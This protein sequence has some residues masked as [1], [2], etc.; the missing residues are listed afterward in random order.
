MFFLIVSIP[1]TYLENNNEN[2]EKFSSYDQIMNS[3][4]DIFYTKEK[5]K[6]RDMDKLKKIPIL[7]NPLKASI[8]KKDI[9]QFEIYLY[10][11]A[12]QYNVFY[13]IFN[14]YW[15]HIFSNYSSN[16]NIF[17]YLI[18]DD[19]KKSSLDLS[20][21]KNRI[22]NFNNLNDLDPLINNAPRSS[23]IIINANNIDP[24]KNS[25]STI[26]NTF[27]TKYKFSNWINTNTSNSGLLMV[28][29][30]KSYDNTYTILNE[31][32]ISNSTGLSIYQT[33]KIQANTIETNGGDVLPNVE[34]NSVIKDINRDPLI[35]S[36]INIISPAKLN[37]DYSLCFTIE[38]N[39]SFV[40]LSSNKL[41]NEI[42]TYSM[43]PKSDIGPTSTT[44]LDTQTPQFWSFEPVT[45]IVTNPLIVFIRTY[46]KPYFYLDAEYENSVMVLKAK[47]FKAGLRQQWELIKNSQDNS[48]YNIRHLKSG[49]NLAY[50]DFDGYL[51]NSDGSVFLSKSN[52]YLWNIK[53]ISQN[54][55]PKILIEN[56]QPNKT[57]SFIDTEVPTDFSTVE[58][59]SW[60]I[61]GNVKGQNIVIESKGRTLWKSNYSPI[62]SGR[63]IYHGTVESY[64]ATLN[65]NTVKFLF[66]RVDS[67]G[68]GEMIDEFLNFTVK[69]ENIGSNILTG[70]IPSGK[71]KDYRVILKLLPTDL[72]YSDPVKA[73][74]V[75]MRYII[76][77]D[78]T[79]FN[80]SSIDINN[81]ESYS[82]KFLGDKLILANFLEASGI[83]TDINLAYS[84][85]NIEII[86]KNIKDQLS[87]SEILKV[88]N[89]FMSNKIK[90]SKLLYKASVN[91]WDPSIFHRL[92]D[93][94]GPTI[95]VA[96]LQDGRFI[97]AYTPLSWNIN[98]NKWIDNKNSFLFDSNE[99][100]TIEEFNFF[101]YAIYQSSYYGPVFGMGHDFLSLPSW[102]PKTLQIYPYSYLNNDK[103]PLGIN[104][105]NYNSF[106][107]KDFEV[108]KITLLNNPENEWQLIPGLNSPMKLDEIS[109]DPQCLSYDETHCE[110][111]YR[112][113]F[114]DNLSY[115]DKNRVNP[116]TCG[117]NHRNKWG[118]DG[119]YEGH[120]CNNL[121][122]HFNPK[123][124]VY[125]DANYQG[126]RLELDIGTHN[127]NSKGFNDMISSLKVPKGL[128][129]EA[130]EHN[131]GQGRKWVFTSN[132]NWVG[133]ANDTISSLIV[134]PIEHKPKIMYGPW[135]SREQKTQI[136]NLNN[137][138]VAHIIFDDIYTK[139]VSS[140][141][142]EKYYQGSID[143][144]NPNN[145]NS[146]NNTGGGKYL[147]R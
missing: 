38:N 48:K 25:S 56:F 58:N 55:I 117:D 63:W 135:I 140:D 28:I 42:V 74:P 50:S 110:W 65:I 119:Y 53:Q 102:S 105:Y 21:I 120:W 98:N 61:S 71:Y 36:K 83:Q 1:F 43:S 144:F 93:N 7:Y 112:S 85:K 15:N 68:F 32:S 18:E 12:N 23:Y 24:I 122:Q 123:V 75:K 52:N 16:N 41:E 76:E 87:I 5:K 37:Q 4:L 116:L 44:K 131:P 80:L 70:M 147:L 92:C 33:I 95:S 20:S 132:T 72:E 60:K 114:G 89:R 104:K 101:P 8:I 145:W 26:K 54:N 138:E 115:I 79:K 121:R 130:W 118:N 27:I 126:R 39:E 62:W 49:M 96:T 142:Q 106:Q 82:T 113:R 2:I 67:N 84:P 59:P 134:K 136:R 78:N 137:G 19:F 128:E 47:R 45:Q 139:M 17:T 10:A 103:G 97:G 13:L 107:L 40:Y 125:S 64:K 90:K 14:N 3:S 29:L 35:N 34:T 22:K 146:Y 91:G 66:I 6:K 108:F 51:Y 57:N 127:V 99:K 124:V 94:E 30:A 9:N 143:Q 31:K 129:V 133:D 11:A 141:G 46:S 109:G 73:F 77:K 69:L 111:N 100:Y 86:N 81:L 88:A